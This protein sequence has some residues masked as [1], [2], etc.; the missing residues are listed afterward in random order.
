V[1]VELL[2]GFAQGDVSVQDEAAQLAAYLV[3]PKATMRLL[4][5]CCAPGGKTCHLL[6]LAP[7]AELLA[8]D[9]DAKRMERVR[10]N[11]QR[12][13][14]KA[15]LKVADLA[16]P[17]TWWDGR[18]FDAILLD[19]PCSA[20]GVVRRHPDIKHLRRASDLAPL[21]K[22]QQRLL[23]TLWSLLKPGGR[24]VYATCSVLP[25]EN[26]KQLQEFT[27]HHPDAVHLELDFPW[28]LT[29][30]FGRQLL[31]QVDGHDGFYYAVLQK[32]DST[33]GP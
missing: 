31:P 3:D 13:N 20:T 12:L 7:D 10:E 2:P 18:P 28:G 25:D 9:I 32:T 33:N 27:S 24:L 6:E 26:V 1:A 14:L 21:A 8:I 15:E 17:H 23:K 19:A 4:D 30:A 29:Q 22:L 16:Q 5:A 11:L